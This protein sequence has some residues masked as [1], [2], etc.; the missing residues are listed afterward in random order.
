M[1]NKKSDTE[2]T[3]DL[4]K[5]RIRA[6][7]DYPK[8]GIMFR[9]ITPLLKD[10][11]VFGKCIDLMAEKVSKYDFDYIAGIE[12]RGF[13]VGSV[14]SYK[15][16]KGFIPIRKKGKLPYAKISKDY[17]LEYGMETIEIHKDSVE[18]DSKVLIVDDLLA[19]GGTA[20]A[21]ADLI[22]SLGAKIS[23]YA[24]IVEL[25]FLEGRK[26]LSGDKVTVRVKY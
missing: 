11:V 21:A 1:P 10:S 25:Q 18:R 2:N 19:T 6:I 4:I 14:L 22:K 26:R 9:D 23:G 15:T 13:I 17:L 12:A 16:G 5:S 24:F 7:P 3:E 20:S 8:P